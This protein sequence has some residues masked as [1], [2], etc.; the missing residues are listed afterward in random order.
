MKRLEE[1]LSRYSFV[2]FF[3][4]LLLLKAN[5][6]F[7]PPVWDEAF[8]I[9][10]AGYFLAQN[11]FDLLELL[12]QPRY[13]FGG[14]N[15]H[16][17]TWGTLVSALGYRFATNLETLFLSVHVLQIAIAALGLSVWFAILKRSFSCLIAFLLTLI[18]LSYPL[19]T[20]QV[21]RMYL[22]IYQ[23][24]ATAFIFYFLQQ[25]RF[26]GV[27]VSFVFAFFSK[28]SALVLL[29]MI[30]FSILLVKEIKASVRI[31]WSLITLFT[32]T[33]L[34]LLFTELN[35]L[36]SSPTVVRE[37]LTISSCAKIFLSD[38]FSAVPDLMFLTFSAPIC[39]LV[40]L[41]AYRRGELSDS[42]I[43][44]YV[45]SFVL[46]CSAMVMFLFVIPIV[47][48]EE[49][50]ILPRYFVVVLPGLI[51]LL[52]AALKA[53]LRQKEFN[54]CLAL[55]LIFCFLNQ[56]GQFYPEL[57]S[58]S[59]AVAERS[60]EYLEISTVQRRAFAKLD[61]LPREVPLFHSLPD[62]YYARYPLGYV[63]QPLWQGISV[64]TT[65][66][67]SSHDLAVFPDH[68]FAYIEFP[69]LGGK[70]LKKMLDIAKALPDYEVNMVSKIEEGA[71]KAEIYSVK[72]TTNRI[73]TK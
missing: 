64:S 36:S 3:A 10:P 71:A 62:T 28:M 50:A 27:L 12:R 15:V 35:N 57:T 38:Y 37:D 6:L 19:F 59:I 14:P 68:F 9:F 17:L 66:P 72:R 18:L 48:Q 63:S 47:Q 61:Q 43:A 58:Q 25:A 11:G 16:S 33:A 53:L 20:V 7:W 31:V 73:M 29:P 13:L 32:G 39:F 8:S 21:G 34:Y 65:A 40:L 1:L 45:N 44:L 52:F 4:L 56:G 55:A 41:S 42:Q 23:F 67:Y 5:V 69:H 30:A 26:L 54:I 70:A 24:T 22:E 46:L 2:V 60:N 49:C 51:L